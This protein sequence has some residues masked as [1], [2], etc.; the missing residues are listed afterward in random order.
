[1]LERQAARCT[2]TLTLLS[3]MSQLQTRLHHPLEPPRTHLPHLLYLLRHQH[4]HQ[5][6]THQPLSAPPSTNAL[7]NNNLG[8]DKDKDEDK[9]KDRDQVEGNEQTNQDRQSQKTKAERQNENQGQGQKK[10]GQKE[11]AATAQ[12]NEQQEPQTIEAVAREEK[13]PSAAQRKRQKNSSKTLKPFGKSETEEAASS[14]C[15]RV[16]VAGAIRA[17]GRVHLARRGNGQGEHSLLQRSGC[18]RAKDAAAVDGRMD[19]VQRRRGSVAERASEELLS[20]L[21]L[22]TGIDCEHGREEECIA[23][24]QKCAAILPILDVLSST[25]QRC[26]TQDY[27]GRPRKMERTFHRHPGFLGSQLK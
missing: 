15:A 14:K 3:T 11:A 18:I 7:D 23:A 20:L 17:P 1:M 21:R 27:T 19:Q 8:N 9:D 26:L 13:T 25:L 5:H 16:D 22:I 10:K 24:M 6:Y 2:R 4:Q 12:T